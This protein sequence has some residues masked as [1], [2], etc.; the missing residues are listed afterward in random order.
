[1]M[2]LN[3]RFEKCNDRL[4]VSCQCTW[5]TPA[6]IAPNACNWTRLHSLLFQVAVY[7]R[8]DIRI[9]HR[10]LLKLAGDVT[11]CYLGADAPEMPVYMG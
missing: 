7:I 10:R 8:G 11:N 5:A 6:W 3:L 4:K 9:L 2:I 1:M